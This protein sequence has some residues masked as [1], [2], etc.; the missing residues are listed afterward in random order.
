[1]RTVSAAGRILSSRDA[2]AS[3]DVEVGAFRGDG[4]ADA[5]F[6]ARS[7]LEAA[8]A[9]GEGEAGEASDHEGE[10]IDEHFGGVRFVCFGGGVIVELV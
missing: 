6:G 7:D 2:D 10:L 9:A 3:A 4:A 8:R 5:F 1:M